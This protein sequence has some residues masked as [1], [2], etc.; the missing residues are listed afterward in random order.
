MERGPGSLGSSWLDVKPN[1]GP[2]LKC[3]KA[4]GFFTWS[5]GC[6]FSSSTLRD[7]CSSTKDPRKVPQSW[8]AVFCGLQNAEAGLRKSDA[9]ERLLLRKLNAE[10]ANGRGRLRLWPAGGRRKLVQCPSPSGSSS[11]SSGKSHASDA[12]VFRCPTCFHGRTSGFEA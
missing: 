6:P 10:L 4:S 11:R 9:C 2:P 3:P 5:Q 7:C 12:S 8:R 1:F